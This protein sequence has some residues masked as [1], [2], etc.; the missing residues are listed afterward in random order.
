MESIFVLG[1]DKAE[2]L[3]AFQQR[4]L[5]YFLEVLTEEAVKQVEACG[6]L[7]SD[8]GAPMSGIEKT[9]KFSC[10]PIRVRGILDNPLVHLPSA[11][12]I[13]GLSIPSEVVTQSQ[14]DKQPTYNGEL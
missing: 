1:K 11:C 12:K 5:S 6:E 13:L 14:V 4:S 10:K 8:G 3:A 2:L 7:P 9:F